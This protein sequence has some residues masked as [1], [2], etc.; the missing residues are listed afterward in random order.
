VLTL[1]ELAEFGVALV[2]LTMRPISPCPP[3]AR[4]AGM[5]AEFAEF[6]REISPDSLPAQ[7]GPERA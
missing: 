7:V 6:E 2:S 1:R 5:V 3:A 4:W